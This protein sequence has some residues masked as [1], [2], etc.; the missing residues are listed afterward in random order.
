MDHGTIVLEVRRAPKK[1]DRERRER[2]L[3]SDV[4]SRA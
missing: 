2:K 1:K 3:A 4:F